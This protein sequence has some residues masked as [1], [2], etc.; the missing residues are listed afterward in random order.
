MT[1]ARFSP[2]LLWPRPAPAGSP[3]VTEIGGV[4][5]AARDQIVDD[6][7]RTVHVL[8]ADD[9]VFERFGELSFSWVHPGV[10]EGWH[11]HRTATVNYACPVG[12]VR[13]AL[14]DARPSSATR[15]LTRDIELSPDDHWLVTVPPGVWSGFVGRGAGD[16]MVCNCATHP[17]DPGEVV[18]RPA[19]DATIGYPWPAP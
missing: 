7:G 19:D 18:R 6:R 14:H 4:R 2:G 11:L 1:L 8:R 17:L 13:L 15:D 5:L 10:V 12:R 16:S 9:A 3:S